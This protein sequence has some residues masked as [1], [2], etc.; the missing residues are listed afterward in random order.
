MTKAEKKQLRY[1]TAYMRMAM[2]WAKLSHCKRKASR[3]AY[4]ERPYDYF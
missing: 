3:L 1:D 4:C 2:E